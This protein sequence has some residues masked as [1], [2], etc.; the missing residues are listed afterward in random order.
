MNN[1]QRN[2]NTNKIFTK[3]KTKRVRSRT[4]GDGGSN[5]LKGSGAVS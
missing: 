3:Y 5:L 4:S 2:I 1:D